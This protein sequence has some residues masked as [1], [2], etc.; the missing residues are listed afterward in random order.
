[1]SAEGRQGRLGGETPDP[2]G[3]LISILD[4]STEYS[5]M[6]E[7]L[8]GTIRMWNEGARRIYGYE[9]REIIGVGSSVLHDSEDVEAG[10]PRA[11]LAAA[12]K[13][14]RWKGVVTGRRK[15]GETFPV[16]LVVAPHRDSAGTAVGF[17]LISKDVSDEIRP[18]QELQERVTFGGA[19]AK[20]A[21]D[22]ALRD[23][24]QRTRDL[25]ESAQ[26]AVYVLSAGGIILDVN[27]AAEEL[28]RAPREEI[29]G[30]HLGEIVPA[31][32][33][34]SFADVFRDT[35]EGGSIR[36]FVTR[37]LRDD[38]TSISIEV[39]A[40]RTVIGGETLVHAIARDVS[41]RREADALVRKLSR[42]VD[43][44]GNAIFMTD[45]AGVITYVNSAFTAVYGYSREEIVGRNPRILKSGLHDEAFY[46]EF[47][48][49]VL[50]GGF[51]GEM[52]NR[53]RDG[54]LVTVL[55]SANLVRGDD[56]DSVGYV[57][58]QTDVTEIRRIAEALRRSEERVRALTE[59]ARDG[60]VVCDRAGAVVEVNRAIETMLGRDRELILGR[61]L[62]DFV[63]LEDRAAA[64]RQ[65]AVAAAGG[66]VSSV[67]LNIRGAGDRTIP[68]EVSAT[69]TRIGEETLLHGIVRDMSERRRLEEELRESHKM[70]A[71]GR[72]AGGIA[73]DF[74][75][76][77]MIMS[78]VAD[79]LPLH[80]GDAAA[81][82]GDID[83]LK[84]ATE[85]GAALI[86]QLLAFSRR[87]AVLPEVL[88]AP[89]VVVMLGRIIE[90]VL[91]NEIDVVISSD[92]DAGSVRVDRGQIE[93]ALLNLV[94]NARDAMPS[95]GRLELSVRQT[96]IGPND[97]LP[98]TILPGEYVAFG[99]SDT[100]AGIPNDVRP[101][102]FEPFFTTG[103]VGRGTG[104]GLATVYGIVRE[105]GGEILVESEIGRGTS[106]KVLLP[107]VE[108]GV[109]DV[110]TEDSRT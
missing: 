52:V 36:G 35:P 76:L 13:D 85:R 94:L 33:R 47:W 79:L 8:E 82:D 100:G 87:Q 40:S 90:R 71:V 16:R 18:S 45:I 103:S 44:S 95:G 64:A 4:S 43:Q 57:A 34:G 89:E 19:S 2:L 37:A 24:Q 32:D 14:G 42:A 9:E 7:D 1:M 78:G 10:K 27:R 65:L 21:A 108:S 98:K 12:L 49:D 62:I 60:I 51:R 17:L 102:I 68:V 75:N 67:A 48:K 25:M 28:Q 46:R 91:G 38:G 15:S 105:A 31:A 50:A 97:A 83:R 80:S 56:G 23:A 6:I 5:M 20:T 92:P 110:I 88:N 54:S 61:N 101:H 29:V 41:R 26:D 104:L 93:Q 106:F 81:L 55:S 77:L 99:V 69:M 109:P 3:L 107:A 86:R 66:V 70:E 72:L 39:S 74:N 63:S 11:I 22:K 96:R 84:H 30:R 73:H 53:A 58:V 59:N